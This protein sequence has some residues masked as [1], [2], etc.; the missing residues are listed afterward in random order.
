MKPT[1]FDINNVQLELGTYNTKY[2]SH[3]IR[4]YYTTQDNSKTDLI[5]HAPVMFSYGVQEN[6][7]S[8]FSLPLVCNENTKSF[9]NVIEQ[10]EAKCKEFMASPE[11][12]KMLN[13]AKI[14][15]YTE[16]MTTLYRKMV[17]GVPCETSSPVLYV[18][19]KTSFKDPTKITTSFHQ[20]DSINQE[21]VPL[22]PETL[23]TAKF[24]CMVTCDISS[25]YCG[26]KPSLQ[27][28]ANSVIVGQRYGQQ[29]HVEEPKAYS[30]ISQ[31]ELDSLFA[32]D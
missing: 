23:G 14:N 3:R 29:Q 28:K 7:N 32:D 26:T 20:I 6:K 10:L 11:I 16:S 17:G 24:K 13:K 19:L 9:L 25:V 18:R 8:G 5:I 4:I 22:S 2:K 30:D 15:V 21:V 12:A 27:I 31:E 1:E